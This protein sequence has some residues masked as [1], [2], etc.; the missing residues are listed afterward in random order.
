MGKGGRGVDGELYPWG[1][2]PLT[3]NLANFGGQVGDTSRAGSYPDGT[4]PY[5]VL[6]MA[7]NVA[8]WVADWYGEDFY[9]NSVYHNP[10]GPQSGEFRVLRGGRG[11][12]W[13]VR[14]VQRFV[15][16]ITRVCKQIQSVFVVLDEWMRS[17]KGRMWRN[18]EDWSRI[19]RDKSCPCYIWHND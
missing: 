4:S 1:N 6:D 18:G 17:S 16:G 12:I 14:C 3:P 13:H 10:T 2:K 11:L 8:E 9:A 15:F 5:G 7:G 19:K